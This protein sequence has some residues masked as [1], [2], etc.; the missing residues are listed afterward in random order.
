[1]TKNKYE[2][3]YDSIFTALGVPTDASPKIAAPSLADLLGT[4]NPPIRSAFP[5][6]PAP[7]PP[8]KIDGIS[9]YRSTGEIERF[10]EPF[11]F[12][13]WLPYF[14]GIYAIL[15]RASDWQP[16]QFKPIYFGQSD[17]IGKRV[18]TAHEKYAS[19]VRCAG[20]GPSLYVAFRL[21]SG[22]Q[23][24]RDLLESSLIARYSP[25][26]NVTHNAFADYYDGLMAN[27]R[28]P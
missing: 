26:C 11:P 3:L 9:F 22:S 19:W 1:L 8:P 10:S 12:G 13:T 4:Y 2:G 18:T 27:R 25:P 23:R 20:Q 15:V 16:R 24:D 21:T 14:R 6:L 7:V 28:N 5:P 17:S